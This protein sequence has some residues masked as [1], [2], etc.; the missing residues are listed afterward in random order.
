MA[1]LPW[2]PW[3]LYGQLVSLTIELQRSGQVRSSA[4]RLIVIFMMFS[5]AL[6][7]LA[8]G[9]SF[10]QDKRLDELIQNRSQTLSAIR[11]QLNTLN[12]TIQFEMRDAMIEAAKQSDQDTANRIR[13]YYGTIC[14]SINNI[15]Q[16]VLATEKCNHNLQ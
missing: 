12:N 10:F 15:A 9:V 11:E 5:I 8:Y 7:V 2:R 6:T 14:V 16:S 13:T 3:L 1:P 4:Q